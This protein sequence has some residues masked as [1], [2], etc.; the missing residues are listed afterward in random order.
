MTLTTEARVFQLEGIVNAVAV[1][2]SRTTGGS[3]FAGAEG[4]ATDHRG[5]LP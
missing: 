3:Y 4:A 5:Q 2:S 1:L